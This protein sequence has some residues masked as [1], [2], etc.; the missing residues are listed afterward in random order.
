MASGHQIAVVEP[1]HGRAHHGI[2]VAKRAV[3]IPRLQE[4]VEA[5]VDVAGRAIGVGDIDVRVLLRIP[6]VLPVLGPL[7][8][9]FCVC[10]LVQGLG[11]FCDAKVVVGVLDCS[12]DGSGEC[13]NA[14]LFMRTYAYLPRDWGGRLTIGVKVVSGN[15]AKRLPASQSTASLKPPVRRLVLRNV[16]FI[17]NKIWS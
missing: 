16:S 10:R 3:Q 2:L 15:I 12:G 1:E 7:Q 13:A 11:H 6:H 14:W 9:L 8:V 4:S 17:S 5:A